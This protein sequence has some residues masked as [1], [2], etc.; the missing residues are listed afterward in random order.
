MQVAGLGDFGIDGSDGGTGDDYI[1]TLYVFRDVPFKDSGAQRGQALRDAGILEVGAGDFI[2][3]IQQD[4]GN[5]AH[6]DAA[7]AYEMDA[8]DFRKHGWLFS[9]WLVA[10]GFPSSVL[11]GLAW[12]ELLGWTTRLVSVNSGSQVDCHLRDVAR[13]IGMG[14]FS[15]GLAHLLQVM[16]VGKQI[17]HRFSQTLSG[18]VGFFE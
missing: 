17:C 2:A 3:K 15:S 4:L 11:L 1:S 5:A 8:L 16:T 9:Y 7:D 18:Q 14:E 10:G 12:F 6:A 13:G